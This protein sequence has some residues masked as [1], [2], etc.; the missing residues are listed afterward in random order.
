MPELV[1][2]SMSNSSHSPL[3]SSLRLRNG[4]CISSDSVKISA[5]SF[6][7]EVVCRCVS[8]IRPLLK[9]FLLSRELLRPSMRLG[10]SF[11]ML[12]CGKIADCSHCFC[13]PSWISNFGCQHDR[14]LLKLCDNLFNRHHHSSIDPK[15]QL[16]TR[17]KQHQTQ[18]RAPRASLAP[19][20]TE[21]C[22]GNC[23]DLDHL[24]LRLSTKTLGNY[25]CPKQHHKSP[26]FSD[27]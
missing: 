10:V 6:S 26:R 17:H 11:L 3:Q 13:K 22:C 9:I 25:T 24:L 27:T 2:R 14:F 21:D 23:G 19:P 8:M 1:L 4:S 18:H 15:Q 5:F 12:S 16:A 20:P 7:G